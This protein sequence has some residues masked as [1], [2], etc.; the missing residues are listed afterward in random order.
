MIKRR[1][2]R[3][4]VLPVCGVA[5]LMVSAIGCTGVKLNP[6][7]PS[8]PPIVWPASPDQARV[9]Y[10]GALTGS[11]DA[12][13]AKPLSQTWDELW[14]G[15]AAPSTFVYPYGVAVDGSS[16]RVAVADTNGRCVHV[17]DLAGRTYERIEACGTEPAVLQSPIAVAW[18]AGRLWIADPKRQAVAIVESSTSSRWVTCE[19]MNRPSGLA[20]CPANDLCYVAD[21]GAHVIY[22]FDRSGALQF[23]FGSHGT[24]PGQFNR[25]T[26]LAVGPG[27]VLVVAD[28]LNFRVQRL[29]LDGRVLSVFG[30]KGDATGDLAL[31]KGVAVDAAGNV[32]V[33]DAHFE[34][35]QAFTPDGQLLMTIGKEGQGIGEFSLPAGICIDGRDRMWIADVYNRRVQVFE[36]LSS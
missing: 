8:G 30:Q 14:Y 5:W 6:L 2:D 28:S 33:V 26:H 20:Y 1:R 27:G 24:A 19:G 10:L 21:A 3:R 34:N 17:L 18:V 23:Q 13:V 16:D 9:R 15:P 7:R 29:G 36:L 31:P 11:E 35:V 22:A 32:W 12:R 25:P 4:R